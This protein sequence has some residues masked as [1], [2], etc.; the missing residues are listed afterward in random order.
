MAHLFGEARNFLVRLA[1]SDDGDVDGVQ[2]DYVIRKENAA[3][4]RWRAMSA[5]SEHGPVMSWP[6]GEDGNALRQRLLDQRILLLGG[7]LDDEA[8]GELI[9]EMLLLSSADPRSE[10][11][12]YINSTGGSAGAFLAVYDTMQALSAPVA[13]ICMSQAKGTAALLLAAGAIGKRLAFENI[14]ILIKFP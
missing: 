13:T 2:A 12:L 14:L 7:P 10:I 5:E 3:W 4:L 11:R 8:A 6:K 9:G 1:G